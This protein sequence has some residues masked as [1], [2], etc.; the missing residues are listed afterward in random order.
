[1]AAVSPRPAGTDAAADDLAG[2]LNDLGIDNSNTDDAP[3]PARRGRGGAL[4]PIES[5]ADAVRALELVCAYLEKHE[6]TN[7][8][9][10]LLRRAQRLI[11]R[12]FLQLVREF[13]PDA[14]NEVARML[15]VDPDSLPS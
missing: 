12:N 5:R 7:P 2:M 14:V 10:D 8:A 4:G 3:A 13:A 9:A 1:V 15:G 11:D 6:P